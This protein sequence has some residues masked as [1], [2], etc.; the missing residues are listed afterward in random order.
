MA[1]STHADENIKTSHHH[2]LFP[3]HV[4]IFT[5]LCMYIIKTFR[6]FIPTFRRQ[7]TKMG[8]GTK[9]TSKTERKLFG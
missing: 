8:K 7:R 2:V 1:I 3:L 9:K 4:H 5:H 6:D